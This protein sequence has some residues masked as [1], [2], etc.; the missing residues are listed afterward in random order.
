V[1]APNDS[2]FAALPFAIYNTL[3]TND[4]FIPHLVDLLLYHVLPGEVFSTDLSDGLTVAAANGENLLI[5]LPP[6]AVNGNEVVSA[7][8]DVSNGVVRITDGVLIPSWVSN[9][10]AS[11]VVAASDLS[12][13]LALVV[14]AELDGDDCPSSIWRGQTLRLSRTITSLSTSLLQLTMFSGNAEQSCM[15]MSQSFGLTGS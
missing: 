1:F 9:S 8:N 4:E 14:L 11:L 2:A 13:L 3:L 15:R 7:D 6:I 5:T 12:T 10:I